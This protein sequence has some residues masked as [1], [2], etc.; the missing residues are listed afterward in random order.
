VT[1][2]IPTTKPVVDAMIRMFDWLGSLPGPIP[3]QVPPAEPGAMTDAQLREAILKVSVRLIDYTIG[4]W[5][6][7]SFDGRP[8]SDPRFRRPMPTDLAAGALVVIT[9]TRIRTRRL[10][11]K[12]AE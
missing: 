2:N 4:P 11:M 10:P 3:G 5:L 6:M 12:Q 7:K 8:I 1:G 9:D